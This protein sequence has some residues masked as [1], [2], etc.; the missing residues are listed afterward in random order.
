MTTQTTSIEDIFHPVEHAILS[1]WLKRTRPA[2]AI[3]VDLSD[4]YERV[5]P[6]DYADDGLPAF[7]NDNFVRLRTLPHNCGSGVFNE[8]DNAV[9]RICLEAI[10]SR[11]PQWG[12]V[13]ANGD[14]VIGR[15]SEPTLER[16]VNLLPQHILEIN[17]ATSGPG[18]AWPES[19]NLAFLPYYDV[20]V[21][22]ASQDSPDVHG[23]V[24]EAIAWFGVGQDRAEAAADVLREY[25][26]QQH[27]ESEQQRWESVWKVGLLSKEDAN[28]LAD[29][30]WEVDEEDDLESS[31]S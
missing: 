18:Y 5:D 9:A 21:V 15:A 28:R 7:H 10:Q 27:C 20:F 29:E 8:L 13:R 25:W 11:L 3:D 2:C 22:T 26:G 19:Y 16:V 14:V 12:A 23:Y 31:Y 17:W 24:D 4:Y 30:V 6:D 1:D